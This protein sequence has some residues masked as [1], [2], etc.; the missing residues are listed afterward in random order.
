M[1]NNI[2]IVIPSYNEV[3]NISILIK[4]ISQYLPEA[5]VIIVDD[6][7]VGEN[8]KLRKIVKNK[9]NITLISRMKKSGRGSA[10]IEGFRESLKD[11][12]MD[13][14]F[15]MDSDLAHDPAEFKRF[16]EKK[17]SGKFDLIIGS[18]YLPGGRI[19]N[20]AKN[21]TILSRVINIFLRS[22]L[23]VQASD[24]TSGFRLYSR[25]AV[26]YLTKTKIKAKGFITLSEVLYKL[27]KEG[28]RIGEVPITWNFRKYGKS[29]V[30]SAELLNSLL[31]VLKMRI[32]G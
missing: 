22:W 13:Y 32:A 27:Y 9:K 20:I 14:V 26:L 25:D 29:N 28:F 1:K 21:R 2:S 8:S 23:G 30:N 17:D 6:S 4:G 3:K 31:F 10:V 7:S 5:K 19:K 15:E 24:F 11:K 12:N 18:R 16:M